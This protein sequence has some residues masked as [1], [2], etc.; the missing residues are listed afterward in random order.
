MQWGT[1]VQGVLQVHGP[2]YLV[3]RYEYFNPPSPELTLN[4][5]T[6]GAVFKPFPFVALKV[7]YRFCDRNPDD[8]PQG[9]FSSFTTFF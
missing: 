1:Y 8:N 6:L 9:F 7:E 3:G 4:L 2:F 5:F